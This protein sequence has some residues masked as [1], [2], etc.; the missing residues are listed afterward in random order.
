M[1]EIIDFDKWYAEFKP[2]PVV[3]VAVF[4]PA[5]GRVISVGP[6]HA[7]ENEKNKIEIDNETAE[8]II[9]T[10]IKIHHCLVDINSKTLEIAEVKSIYKIDDVLHRV[11]SKDYFDGDKV[12][13][14]LTYDS[15]KKTLKVQLSDE[16]G[17]TKKSKKAVKQ[18]NIVWDG[19]T[20]MKF[21]ITEYNDPNLIFEMLSVKINELVG[22]TKTFKNID[23][24]KF[25]VYTRRFFKNYVIETK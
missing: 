15:K 21:L 17:G 4:D 16:F 22:K 1:E 9:N 5:T 19:D 24:P 13:V 6:S 2:Q 25:S 7:F 20:E 12:D 23:Y 10:E 8:A 14:F 18:R 3:Y 11:I